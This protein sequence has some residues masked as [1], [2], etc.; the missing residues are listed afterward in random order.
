MAKKA[1][2]IWIEYVFQIKDHDD[3]K[4]RV[5][6]D[7]NTLIAKSPAGS[8]EQDWTRL[9]FAK[10]EI[11]PLSSR[12]VRNCPIAYN[13]SGLA[14]EFS[15]FYSIHESLITVNVA[16]RSY[17]KKDTVQQGL[18]SILGIYLATSGCPH[19]E[20]LKPMARFHLP[21]ASVE[22]TIY[23]HSCNFLLGQF[24]EFLDKGQMELNMQK[25]IDKYDD[26]NV[27]NTGICNR[28]ER[29][30]AGDANKNALIILNVI[31]LMLKMELEGNLKSLKYLFKKSRKTGA[32]FKK[33][34][35]N[36]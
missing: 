12:Q 1:G 36:K 10:C 31:G 20:I 23:R 17:V 34:S 15:Q 30:T 3:K 4:F 13:I 35:K 26:I 28:I 19:M 27:V 24:F 6:L 25:L 14:T 9:N 21:F 29:I 33:K 18:R 5:V 7:K 32:N 8:T 2:N 11:C 16:E 22:E